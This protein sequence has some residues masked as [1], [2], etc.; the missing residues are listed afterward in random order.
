MVGRV[1][2]YSVTSQSLVNNTVKLCYAS[3][4]RLRVEFFNEIKH[5]RSH[6]I[7]KNDTT[8]KMSFG[9]NLLLAKIIKQLNL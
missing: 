6:S 4:L 5:V 2:H 8:L 3:Y 9:A 1:N 7:H